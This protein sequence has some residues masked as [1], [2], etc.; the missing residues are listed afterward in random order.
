MRS[1]VSDIDV[2]Y[3]DYKQKSNGRTSSDLTLKT[4]I[5]A[6]RDNKER[7]KPVKDTAVAEMTSQAEFT[8]KNRKLNQYFSQKSHLVAVPSEKI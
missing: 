3:E 5:K 7:K 8:R 4:M 1:K 6:N 2:V